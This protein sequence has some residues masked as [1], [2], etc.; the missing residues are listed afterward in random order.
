M[1]PINI[2]LTGVTGYIGDSVLSALLRHP[3]LDEFHTT[4][5]VRSEA[6]ASRFL[7]IA[8]APVIG[9]YDDA[10]LQPRPMW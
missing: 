5:L 1:T 7:S 6:K 3:R 10:A 2:C 4:A 8:V 9:S